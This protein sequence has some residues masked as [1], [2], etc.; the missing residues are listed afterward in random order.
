M[1]PGP[2]RLPGRPPAARQLLTRAGDIGRTAAVRACFTLDR[3]RS[4]GASGKLWVTGP[5]GRES[6]RPSPESVTPGCH[7]ITR[8]ALR[9]ATDDQYRL[10]IRAIRIPN[11]Q[12]RHRV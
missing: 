9:P 5:R 8:S 12:F 10:N 3:I 2:G 7:S 1:C 4:F 6:A 11:D